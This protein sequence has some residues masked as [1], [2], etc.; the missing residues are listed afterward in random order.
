MCIFNSQS[1][2][3]LVLYRFAMRG[4]FL[5]L[6]L[7]LLLYTSTVDATS[8]DLPDL[9]ACGNY[10]IASSMLYSG[11]TGATIHIVGG[12]RAA[13]DQC[14]DLGDGNNPIDCST[15]VLGAAG[16]DPYSGFGCESQVA[17]AYSGLGDYVCDV[18]YTGAGPD[19]GNFPQPMLPG[20]FCASGGTTINGVA[21]TQMVFDAQG[22]C[23][24]SWIVLADTIEFHPG[25]MQLLNCAQPTRI[26]F[27]ANT[28]RWF[29][30]A[31]TLGKFLVSSNAIAAEANATHSGQILVTSGQGGSITTTQDFYIAS[32]SPPCQLTDWT[33]QTICPLCGATTYTQ[34]RTYTCNPAGQGIVNMRT[35]SCDPTPACPHPPDLRG[36]SPYGLFMGT[37]VNY[38]YGSEQISG[39]ASVAHN[40]ALQSGNSV[41]VTTFIT[42]A[43]AYASVTA[44]A[45]AQL[46][47]ADI[48]N[49]M[50]TTPPCQVF[51]DPL[52]QSFP[53]GNY[54]VAGVY[55]TQPGGNSIY[56]ESPTTLDALGDPSAMFV[57]QMGSTLVAQPFLLANG[58]Q[59]SN[60][61]FYVQN[62]F[63]TLGSTDLIGTVVLGSTG[64]ITLSGGSIHGQVLWLGTQQPADGNGY[65]YGS[66]SLTYTP[67]P[68]TCAPGPV[69]NTTSCPANAVC[70]LTGATYT[71]VQMTLCSNGA[72][73]VLSNVTHS[74]N[75]PA[76]FRPSLPQCDSHA[77]GLV[78]PTFTYNI[79]S[80]PSPTLLNSIVNGSIASGDG[81]CHIVGND[82]P[83][84]RCFTSTSH[85]F[86]DTL[87]APLCISD[88]SAAVDLAAALHCD[89]TS[90]GGTTFAQP[91]YGG[92]YCVTGN[93]Q[94]QLIWTLDGSVNQTK[95]AI[96]WTFIL[97]GSVTVLNPTVIFQNGARSSDLFTVVP[98]VGN[99]ADQAGVTQFGTLLVKGSNPLVVGYQGAGV[100]GAIYSTT[101]VILTNFFSTPM[102][103]VGPYTIQ[104]CTVTPWVNTTACTND[105][106]GGT[107]NQARTIIAPSGPGGFG[108]PS[109]SQ[110][111]VPCS[112]HTCH[113]TTPYNSYSGQVGYAYVKSYTG[114]EAHWNLN[115]SVV[116]SARVV[117]V[118]QYDST[119]TILRKVLDLRMSDVTCTTPLPLSTPTFNTTCV[120]TQQLGQTVTVVLRFN[121][122]Y[123]QDLSRGLGLTNPNIMTDGLVIDVFVISGWP[124]FTVGNDVV[125]AVLE[126]FDVPD[127]YEAGLY[128]SPQKVLGLPS[129]GGGVN[130][131]FPPY[132]D[133][134]YNAGNPQ[135]CTDVDALM[136]TTN[137]IP[138]TPACTSY[139]Y[140]SACSLVANCEWTGGPTCVS[141]GAAGWIPPVNVTLGLPSTDATGQPLDPNAIPSTQVVTIS[142]PDVNVVDKATF[143]AALVGEITTL[144][145]LVD[146][147]F[148]QVAAIETVNHT[149]TVA[150]VS[151]PVTAMQ[152]LLEFI[153]LG[154]TALFQA[155]PVQFQ[156]KYPILFGSSSFAVKPQ[157]VDGTYPL[158]FETEFDSS[159]GNGTYCSTFPSSMCTEGL[160]GCMPVDFLTDVCTSGSLPIASVNTTFCVSGS[161]I[162]VADACESILSTADQL[163]YGGCP[164]A[165]RNANYVN[166]MPFR[167]YCQDP[168]QPLGSDRYTF[169][170]ILGNPFASNGTRYTISSPYTLDQLV[171]LYRN[172]S[173]G[174]VSFQAYVSNLFQN[175]QP[176][177]SKAWALVEFVSYYSATT[178]VQLQLTRLAFLQPV[179]GGR[180]V[181]YAGS[182]WNFFETIAGFALPRGA[183]AYAVNGAVQS[184]CLLYTVFNPASGACEPGCSNGYYGTRCNLWLPTTCIIGST[185]DPV[186]TLYV[187]Y[188]CSSYVCQPGYA[189]DFR[190]CSPIPSD[191]S[192][193]S[194]GWT[195]VKFV[196][197]ALGTAIG[198]WGIIYFA[199]MVQAKRGGLGAKGKLQK[200]RKRRHVYDNVELVEN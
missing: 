15:L 46:C 75:I 196:L 174:V 114:V 42:G 80:A 91:M 19:T 193:D 118:A 197:V 78:A 117:Q 26:L 177:D 119:R 198:V 18:S 130:I 181:Y 176:T 67:P 51:A 49:A 7:L 129:I 103:M 40:G 137:T 136:D 72:D 199:R 141:S 150:Q 41:D 77:L 70:G 9:S 86:A 33:N 135:A 52:L 20:V 97:T 120:S 38:L 88:T 60:V 133:A 190:G 154:G 186:S 93:M 104:D 39:G 59:A 140:A 116:E 62:T 152:V 157:I 43:S 44:S 35:L 63:S 29:N 108:C 98:N 126:G 5:L 94:T 83:L 110:N 143:S 138:P 122:W 189:Q 50:A 10:D 113:P 112:T 171:R 191:S 105:C 71:S 23:F 159:C 95:G 47:I 187:S 101:A 183:Y 8:P 58:A 125:V 145:G 158:P 45:Q 30:K 192:S 54:F 156:Q 90:V 74:C 102:R 185:F 179:E 172:A 144:T 170:G 175:A 188:D 85:V 195:A 124:A 167:C 134:W 13:G 168:S 146:S 123:Y 109:L 96:T 132:A 73:T 37:V 76:C 3:E 162:Q 161:P 68:V 180:A 166:V 173:T 139:A 153:T 142:L 79:G 81:R 147:T 32:Y 164:C 24:A 22:D 92:V 2:G 16:I 163:A 121:P 25:A 89:Y 107:W 28:I 99:M 69:V 165:E 61:F 66:N 111:N 65:I 169:I 84:S 131:W 27:F 11:A 12:G 1:V 149:S 182:Q 178:P 4:L 6:S 36:C 48:V 14:S 57:F 100:Q 127:V 34:T 64:A 31:D 55:C 148:T 194:S 200:R 160:C 82:Y 128:L 87:T 155:N 17:T 53:S 151:M 56:F 21:T 184:S 106:Y 115:C